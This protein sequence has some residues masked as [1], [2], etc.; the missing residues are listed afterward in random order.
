MQNG[1]LFTRNRKNYIDLLFMNIDAIKKA[2]AEARQDQGEAKHILAGTNVISKPTEAAVLRN[3][4]PI[5]CI[6]FMTERGQMVKLRDPELWLKVF[7]SCCRLYAHS[8][9]WRIIRARYKDKTLLSMEKAER[10]QL[11]KFL[12]DCF[13]LAV[14]EKLLK[15][16]V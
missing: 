1:L 15:V 9:T 2:M 16:E 11:E 13:I 14:Q 6:Y 7:V 4:K 3:N 5:Q 10:Q 8:D 12:S